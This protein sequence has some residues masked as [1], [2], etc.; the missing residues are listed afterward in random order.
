LFPNDVEPSHGIF[1]ESRLRRLIETGAVATRVIA[2]VP[3]F[4]FPD[5]RF[6]H[7]AR[8][9]RVAPQE[10]RAGISV[11]HPRYL[12][13]PGIGMDVAPGLLYLGA[14]RSL[15]AVIRAGFDFDLIDAHY[16]YP[17]GVAAVLLGA[18]F[19][20]PVVI[21]ARGTDVNLIADYPLPRRMIRWAARRSAAVISVCQALKDRLVTI[22]VDGRR[23]SVLRN[24]VDLMTFRPRDRTVARA[25]YGLEQ[26][27]IL[28]VGHL[29]RRKGHDIAIE[30]L[31]R[32]EN[33]VL[34]IAGGGPEREALGALA[35]RLGVAARVRFLGLLPQRELP[36]LYSAADLLVLAS[37]REG[38]ANVLLEAMACGTP[39]VASNVW[40]TPEV[41]ASPVAGC[42]VDERSGAAFAAAIARLLMMPPDRAATRAYAERFSGEDTTA[43]QLDIF[44]AIVRGERAPATASG[45]R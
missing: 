39:V 37:T 23:I 40:G 36:E 41:V 42:L 9:A 45:S 21:T 30:A 22:G 44:R 12:A 33:A 11:V 7:Y 28:S 38:W 25:R 1:V 17:D 26:P 2:P 43:G 24:G 6:G 20:K 10:L 35:E 8:Y 5:D 15:R 34:L 16:F 29:I 27:M 14:R 4:P 31:A 18:E 13:L 3:W 19:G 32:V